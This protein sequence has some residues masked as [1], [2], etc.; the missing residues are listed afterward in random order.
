MQLAFS[1]SAESTADAG[2]GDNLEQGSASRIAIHVHVLR[3]GGCSQQADKARSPPPH[4]DI[5]RYQAEEGLHKGSASLDPLC[6]EE[7]TDLRLQRAAL[8]F[9]LAV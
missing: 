5:L 6:G 8:L 9:S 4:P 1:V 7:M 2:H 3:M